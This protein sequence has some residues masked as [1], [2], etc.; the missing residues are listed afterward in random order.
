MIAVPQRD[1]IARMGWKLVPLG[2]GYSRLDGA[3]YAIFVAA[4]DEVSTAEKTSSWSCSAGAPSTRA[5]RY[6]GWSSG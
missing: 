1:D 4:I 2:D 5:G 6:T 3:E